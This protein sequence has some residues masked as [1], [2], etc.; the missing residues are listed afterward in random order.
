MDIAREAVEIC[1]V[2]VPTFRRPKLLQ[3]ALTSL[4][5]QT[6]SHWHCIV[7]DDSPER[8]AESTVRALR[9]PR[10]EYR[11]NS[12]PL[13]ALGNIDKC[14][15]SEPM[16]NGRYAF[17]LEDDNY[18]LPAH[19]EA[20]IGLVGINGTRIAF[21]NQYCEQVIS[22]GEPGV[23]TTETTLK[24]IYDEGRFDPEHLLPTLLFS[25]GFSNGSAFW[26][27]DCK[28][29][30]RI[31]NSTKRPGIQESLRLLRLRE[32]VYVSL[33]PT[34]VWRWNDRDSFVNAPRRGLFTHFIRRYAHIAER[35]EKLECM[36]AVVDRLGVQQILEY[37]KS[38]SDRPIPEIERSL[39]LCGYHESLTDRRPRDRLKL[40]AKGWL[41][42]ATNLK[43]ARLS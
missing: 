30:F 20:L 39:L 43:S 11:H 26:R 10:I 6:Y 1:E 31:G 23:M 22:P 40:L 28:S 37:C 14:F 36:K 34:S 35:Q 5:K 41:L 27:T 25:Q 9:D 19:I 8:S 24:W 4:L 21:S 7:F 38:H 29:Q 18:L 3:R 15:Q 12:K 2:R 13:G 33:S 32:P 17:V 16:L 42:S